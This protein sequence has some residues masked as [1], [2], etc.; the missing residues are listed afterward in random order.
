MVENYSVYAYYG[1]FRFKSLTLYQ[2]YA[3]LWFKQGSISTIFVS[4]FLSE[5]RNFLPFPFS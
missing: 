4:V 3:I 2:T 5:T 1:A